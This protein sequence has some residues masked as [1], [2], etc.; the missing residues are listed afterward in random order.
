[1]CAKYRPVFSFS[2]NKLGKCK[3]SEATFPL[4]PG[5]RLANI[6]PYRANPRQ[7]SFSDQCAEEMIS[8]GVAKKRTNPW[9]SPVT[10]VACK[11]GQPRFC[12][13]YRWTLNKLIVREPWP[14]A[15]LERNLG[16]V[17]AVRLITVANVAS[18]YWQI[19]VHPDHVERTAFVTRHGKYSLKRMPFG[20]CKAP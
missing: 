10:I 6:S 2:Q 12:V 19:P 17:G 18:T 11:D 20:V 8:H 9:G 15:N 16:S 5:S 4:P 1:M 13:D 14:M 3:T 7:E